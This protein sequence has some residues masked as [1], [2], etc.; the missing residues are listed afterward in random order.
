M[1]IKVPYSPATQ[2]FLFVTLPVLL[3]NS[4]QVNSEWAELTQPLAP[5]KHV[6]FRCLER[7]EQV[8][9]FWCPVFSV[10][11]KKRAYDVT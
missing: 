7:D 5:R 6:W 11:Q 9:H 3:E 1:S 4:F 2:L 8:S 10:G